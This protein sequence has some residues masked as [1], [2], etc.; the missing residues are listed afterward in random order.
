MSGLGTDV[1]I[2]TVLTFV[3]AEG[4]SPLPPQQLLGIVGHALVACLVLTTR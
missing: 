2:G 4:F 1:S 3:G